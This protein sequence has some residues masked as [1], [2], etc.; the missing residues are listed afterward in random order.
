MV[1]WQDVERPSEICLLNTDTGALQT[2]TGE[3]GLK[4]LGFIDDDLVYGR[5]AVEQLS[6]EGFVYQ[7]FLDQICIVDANLENQALYEKDQILIGDVEVSDSGV[8][9]ARYS[10]DG[11]VCTPMS[12]DVIF[13]AGEEKPAGVVELKVAASEIKR[14]YY[15]INLGR[16]VT[17]D[18]VTLDTAKLLDTEPVV[19]SAQQ[20]ETEK[21]GTCSTC[22]YGTCIAES[23]TLCAAI[24]AAY[25][26]MGVVYENGYLSEPLWN[27]DARDLYLT[28]TLPAMTWTQ[29]GHEEEM[30]AM[31]SLERGVDIFIYAGVNAGVVDRELAQSSER[32]ACET[33]YEELKL[34]FGD[35]L[36][37]LT[38]SR[39]GYLLYY[40]NLRHPVLCLT[41][42]DTALII[43]GYTSTELM[44]YDPA[45]RETS[46]MSQEDAQTYFDN[47]NTIFVS[48]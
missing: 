21:Q 22:L 36:L 41:E 6:R 8:S 25:E 12:D 48:F 45:T 46:G 38:G 23:E 37:D 19:L 28:M 2:I 47:L 30:A 24:Q 14:N 32:D 40:V 7:H 26:R 10:V 16:T 17:A 44:I 31:S 20:S 5:E 4:I 35:H 33:V 18:K 13:L 1:A 29:E 15:Y 43:T 27:R 3:R 42:E 11:N 9:F 39:I 34:T